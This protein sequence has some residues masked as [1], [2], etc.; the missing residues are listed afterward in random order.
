MNKGFVYLI[1]NCD[2]YKI[3]HTSNLERHLCG[4]NVA[5]SLSLTN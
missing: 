3:G 2:L 4:H 1:R 5:E